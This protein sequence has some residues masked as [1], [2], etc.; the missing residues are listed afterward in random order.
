MLILLKQLCCLIIGLI[1]G[2]SEIWISLHNVPSISNHGVMDSAQS[3]L[4]YILVY[5]P[6]N[7]YENLTRA[8]FPPFCFLTLY[9]FEM[10]QSNKISATC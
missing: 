10:N 9:T 4:R 6:G 3:I 1:K 8:C 5:W 2:K 7:S